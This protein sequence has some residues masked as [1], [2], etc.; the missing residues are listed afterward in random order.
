MGAD[1]CVRKL[2]CFGT[3]VP[4]S[5]RK[6]VLPCVRYHSCKLPI[7]SFCLVVHV[8]VKAFIS[9]QL[10]PNSRQRPLHA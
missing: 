2:R 6:L 4:S 5:V 7:D 8:V 9:G 1:V 3:T 10:E